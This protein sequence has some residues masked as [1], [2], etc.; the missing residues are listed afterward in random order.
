[1]KKITVIKNSIALRLLK[2]VFSTYLGIT[3]VITLTQMTNEYLLE[4]RSVRDTLIVN[5]A[6]FQKNITAAIWNLD[7]EQLVVTVQGILKQ[8]ALV[9]VK[10]VDE[11]GKSLIKK[12]KI[13]NEELKPVLLE[14]NREQPL[15]YISLFQHSFDLVHEG[16]V[17]GAITLYS[18]NHVVFNKVKYNFLAI[19]LNAVIKTMTLWM[20]FIWAF[21]KFLTRQLDV[22]CQTME[23][24]DI[25]NYKSYSLN[26]ETFNTYELSRIEHVFNDLLKRIVENR[27]RLNELNKTLEQKVIERTQQLQSAMEVVEQANR[28]MS[29]AHKK[30][31]DS[32][33]YASLI[34]KAILPQRQ[35][36]EFLGDNQ[37][38]VW[39]PRD[40][41]GGDFYL[42]H[43]DEN[44]YLLGVI[45]CAGHG[46]PG[47]LMTMLARAALDQ[48]VSECGIH[49]PATLLAKMDAILRNRLQNAKMSRGLAVTMDAGLV[50]VDPK[51]Q[52]VLFAAA[53]MSL[54][55][56]DGQQVGEIKGGNRAILGNRAGHYEDIPLTIKP[57]MTF[58]M[59]S[60][61]VLDQAG[62]TEG[63]G[64]GNTR[65]TTLLRQ[66]ATQP[67]SEQAKILMYAVND[68]R[69]NYP[70]RDDITL[71]FFKP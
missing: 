8:P 46:V 39:Q 42:F 34:Q 1:M 66:Y 26:L 53:K 9:G 13:L 61:G 14:N 58:C 24:I 21:N 51:Q 59:T 30:I 10:I 3:I 63:F 68:Y 31:N 57:E 64:F 56:T 50:F 45:D 49:S 18:S 19:I 23:N 43:I 40:V 5:Q 69:G 48:A 29:V 47:S 11:N 60:D 32:I 55:W 71:F 36:T 44:T 4:E 37:E 35:L 38:V 25:D 62:G 20:L 12:G 27:D 54:Y 67:V 2:V 28:E 52:Q 17:I 22:F 70:Q 6:I 16:K 15:L 7:D 41:V 33:E 65:F